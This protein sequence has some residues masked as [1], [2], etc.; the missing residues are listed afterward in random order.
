[1]KRWPALLF[2]SLLFLIP[3]FAGA[4]DAFVTVNL[5]L[6]AGP[7]PEFP[8]IT[9]LPAG[10]SVSVQGCID[11]YYWCDVI[12]GPDRGWVAGEY[13][14]YTYNNRRVYI[15][16]YGARIGIPIVTFAVAAYWDNYYR[17]RSWYGRRD[18]WG[19][20]PPTWHRPPPRPP[21]HNRP[22]QAKP[23]ITRPPQKPKPP[24]TRPPPRPKPPITRPPPKP[25]PPVTR[26]QPKPQP[27]VARPQPKPQPVTRPAPARPQR[28]AVSPPQTRPAPGSKDA[29]K[30]KD[31]GG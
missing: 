1:M 26:P 10:S 12:A 28:P 6:R 24:V 2:A 25:R 3:T 20:R 23:P 18:Y 14:Q 13:L 19:H 27:P 22:P 5:S 8:R 31:G 30:T 9:V 7:D 16:A 29:N 4:A 11:N 15:D 17:N 21:H